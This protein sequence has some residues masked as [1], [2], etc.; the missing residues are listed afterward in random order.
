MI[1]KNELDLDDYKYP[2]YV[3]QEYKDYDANGIDNTETFEIPEELVWRLKYGQIID[4]PNLTVS[5]DGEPVE[6]IKPFNLSPTAGQVCIDLLKGLIKFHSDDEE[7]ECV[8]EYK[9]MGSAVLAMDF[10]S[11]NTEINRHQTVLSGIENYFSTGIFSAANGSTTNPSFTFT[12]DPDTGIYRV[13]ANQLGIA[14]DGAVVATFSDGAISFSKDLYLSNHRLLILDG[15]AVDP[16]VKFVGD[17]DTGIYRVGTDSL[18]ISA[19]GALS[20]GVSS[21]SI[22]VKK[23][24]NLDSNINIEWNSAAAILSTGN[25]IH[26]RTASNSAL[27]FDFGDLIYFRDRDNAYTVMSTINSATGAYLVGNGSA[28]L[29]SLSFYS[30]TNTGIYRIDADNIGISTGGT[31]KLNVST[32][33]VTSILPILHPDGSA[34]EPGI[35]FASSPGYGLWRTGA[36]VYMTI[37]SSATGWIFAGN[38]FGPNG[39]AKQF[40]HATN[41][42]QQINNLYLTAA[43]SIWFGHSSAIEALKMSSTSVQIGGT[44]NATHTPGTL[45]TSAGTVSLPSLSFIADTNTGI[46]NSAADALS[47]TSGGTAVA[48]FGKDISVTAKPDTT[49][50]GS[51]TLQT[52][53]AVNGGTLSLLAGAGTTNGGGISI[54]AGTGDTNGGSITIQSGGGGALDGDISLIANAVLTQAGNVNINAAKVDAN[55]PVIAAGSSS[56]PAF[57]FSGDD[58]TGLYPAG[59]NSAGIAVGGVAIITFSSS[60]NKSLTK[61]EIESNASDALLLLDQNDDDSPFIH[62]EG[63]VSSSFDKNISTFSIDSMTF[64]RFIKVKINSDELWIPAYYYEP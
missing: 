54:T 52:G 38:Q 49:N 1:Y 50:G 12:S 43:A 9:A 30:D 46:Y 18:G 23:T 19:G 8:I 39:G 32:T 24:L 63:D 45:L 59:T 14:A 25:Y 53:N 40:G 33:D 16:A 42:N 20:L 35:S 36:A 3:P 48:S 11:I 27:Y 10:N 62:F 7:K 34:T 17:L 21:T 41:S 60:L 55:C 57:S 47:I 15:T 22:S 6:I 44:S 56:Y 26:L 4:Q 28:S 51:I 13:G 37:G 58:D 31:L 5:I 64:S 61:T 29:P 2:T